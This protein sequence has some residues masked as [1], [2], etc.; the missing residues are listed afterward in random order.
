M[1][2]RISKLL[3]FIL[4]A[5]II[6]CA[7]SPEY[8]VAK[9]SP[10]ETYLILSRQISRDEKIRVHHRDGTVTKMTAIGV[11]PETLDGRVSGNMEVRKIPLEDIIRVETIVDNESMKKIGK[12]L[13]AGL[14]ITGV[15][16]LIAG[17]SG[18]Y[19]FSG[20]SFGGGSQQRNN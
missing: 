2:Y 1:N 3:C 5:C 11:T 17:T 6:G 10:G 9:S 18:G 19:D 13:L 15:V 8:K 16:L 14:I 7:S 12:L 4:I 20:I